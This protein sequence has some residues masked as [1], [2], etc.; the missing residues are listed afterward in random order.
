MRNSPYSPSF[1]YPKN[2][3]FILAAIASSTPSTTPKIAANKTL[4]S[5]G[6]KKVMVWAGYQKK[7]IVF[8]KTK[9]HCVSQL[10]CVMIRVIGIGVIRLRSEPPQSRICVSV[11]L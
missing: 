8:L 6:N 4:T 10:R 3:Y 1:L 5:P 7:G 9:F 11:I 2:H